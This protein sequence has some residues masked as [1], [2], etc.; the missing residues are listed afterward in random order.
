[1]ILFRHLVSISLT[2]IVSLTYFVDGS[3]K[4]V[5]MAEL[6]TRLA[7]FLKYLDQTPTEGCFI[8]HFS[9]LSIEMMMIGVLQL[10]FCANGRLNGP[11]DLES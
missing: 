7:T 1:M 5:S 4:V 2:N 3:W 11:S 8:L 9:T 10:L 6:I